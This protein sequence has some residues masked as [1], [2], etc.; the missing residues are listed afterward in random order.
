MG[1]T[2]KFCLQWN[3]FEAN[4]SSA[5][6][7]LK[8]EK[9]FSDVTLVCADQQVEAHKVILAASSPFFKRVLK[10]VQ[11]SHPLIFLKGVKFSDLESVLSF[12]YNGEANVAQADLK[13]F[14]AVAEELEVIG[15]TCGKNLSEAKS[16][17]QLQLSSNHEP[18]SNSKYRS[19]SNSNLQHQPTAPPLPPSSTQVR[20]Q[21]PLQTQLKGFAIKKNNSDGPKHLKRKPESTQL[22][23]TSQVPVEFDLKNYITETSKGK[24]NCNICGH[25][26]SNKVNMKRHVESKHFPGMYACN[27]C[28]KKLNTMKKYRIHCR[29]HHSKMK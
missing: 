16:N 23:N 24:F 3:D 14:L 4:I 28:E 1:T 10:K 5:F 7:N 15:L 11:H 18:R 22:V 9:D 21:T 27:Q 26:N 8:E 19:Q 20:L 17:H 29:R 25:L 13:N 6:R 12:V 2:E